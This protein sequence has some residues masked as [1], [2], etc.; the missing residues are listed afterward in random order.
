MAEDTRLSVK[1]CDRGGGG[2]GGFEYGY[3]SI[4]TG[5]T[6]GRKAWAGP[7]IVDTKLS[8]GRY[9]NCVGG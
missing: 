1:G 8:V 9:K 2:E 4:T 5:C 7:T 3:V 6:S